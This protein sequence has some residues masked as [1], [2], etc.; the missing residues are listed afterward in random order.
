MTREK[1]KQMLPLIQAFADGE[2][3]E[4]Y[5]SFQLHQDDDFKQGAWVKTENLG[6][7]GNISSYRMIKD[8]KIIYFDNQFTL[9]ERL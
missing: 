9:H 6:V 4:Y 1:C 2:D 8:G 3:I 5:D 7:G